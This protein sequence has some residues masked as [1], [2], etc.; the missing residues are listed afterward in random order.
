MYAP[1]DPIM[2]QFHEINYQ[3]LLCTSCNEKDDLIFSLR[4]KIRNRDFNDIDNIHQKIYE[5]KMY[6]E[7]CKNCDIKKNTLKELYE[8]LLLL[9][10]RNDGYDY[11][12]E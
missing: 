10:Y 7:S 9:K 4:L 2:S 3:P 12:F 8:E 5:K 1:Y 6:T 11:D